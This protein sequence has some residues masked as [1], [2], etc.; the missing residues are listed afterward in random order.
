MNH[1]QKTTMNRKITRGTLLYNRDSAGAD[2]DLG[3]KR[4]VSTFVLPGIELIEQDELA[5]FHQDFTQLQED[6]RGEAG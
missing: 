5:A 3:G 6:E 4:K 2:Q 1:K